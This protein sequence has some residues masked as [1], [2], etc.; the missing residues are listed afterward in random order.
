[1]LDT[2]SSKQELLFISQ[3][4]WEISEIGIPVHIDNL[5]TIRN[6]AAKT[7]KE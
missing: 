6:F 5:S 3:S 7:G 2:Y 4:K 1:M